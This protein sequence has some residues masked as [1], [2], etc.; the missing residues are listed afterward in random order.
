[1][2]DTEYI[3]RHIQN[4]RN[5]KMALMLAIQEIEDYHPSISPK[6]RDACFYLAMYRKAVTSQDTKLQ[7]IAEHD[8]LRIT[9]RGYLVDVLPKLSDFVPIK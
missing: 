8:M 6:H 3:E 5:Y 1:M 4:M 9:G 2:T 7:T